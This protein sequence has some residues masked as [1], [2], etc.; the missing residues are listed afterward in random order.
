MRSAFETSVPARKPKTQIGRVLTE[1]T[2]QPAAIE[3]VDDAVDQHSG[4]NGND[5]P[6]APQTSDTAEPRVPRGEERVAVPHEPVAVQDATRVSSE[7]DRL[8]ALRKRLELAAQPPSLGTEPQ[9]TAA[10]VRKHIDELRA[11]AE[12]A[13][14]DRAELAKMLEETRNALRR[15]EAEL[16]QERKIRRQVE[17][18]A[19]E[20]EQVALD[21]VAEAEALAGE[22]D[23]VL[24]ELA[25]RH[26]LQSE[27][28]G[29][30]AEAETALNR[31]RAANETA[32]RELADA[33]HLL[34][35]RATEIS[36]LETRIQ[37]EAAERARSEARCRELE[38]ELARMAQT[39]E[40]LAAIK[41]MVA[42]R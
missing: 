14:R 30:L 41:E 42:P 36:D 25:E 32:A 4:P 5:I 3:P 40:A 10:A 18:Q 29:L 16:E 12:G 2:T 27:E 24:S 26:R 22:R 21:A 11:R 38:G 37:T 28:R 7:W 9:H 8:A 17:T 19:A 39:A 13:V 23:M 15:A 33:R 20:R 6:A 34:D 31:H 35:L 1:L